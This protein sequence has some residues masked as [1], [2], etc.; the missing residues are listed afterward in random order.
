MFCP[1]KQHYR[2]ANAVHPVSYTHLDVYKRQTMESVL[3]YRLHTFWDNHRF[4]VITFS[5]GGGINRGNTVWN[6]DFL[7]VRI[8]L[9]QTMTYDY[10][11]V[12]IRERIAVMEGAAVNA[13]YT[14][15]LRYKKIFQFFTA[16]KSM[17]INKFKTGW[18]VY[19]SKV[20]AI[21][22]CR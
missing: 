7:C 18:E 3:F 9:Y 19:C 12:C 14:F 10:K 20:F 17:L 6:Y 1:Q 13:Y 15:R 8:A 5:K 4:Q 2:L 16:G 11:A 21:F 22:K